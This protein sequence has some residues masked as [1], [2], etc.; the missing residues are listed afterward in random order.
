[1]PL[2]DAKR[3]DFIV[4]NDADEE[5][6]GDKER[7]LRIWSIQPYSVLKNPK[8]GNVTILSK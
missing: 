6:S 2:A 8:A 5:L 4:S 1:M 3:H 7:I